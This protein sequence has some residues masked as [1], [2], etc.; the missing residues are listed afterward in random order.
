MAQEQQ[1]ASHNAEG[2]LGP[3]Q[4]GIGL[5]RVVALPAEHALLKR[6]SL[7]LNLAA[8]RCWERRD[9]STPHALREEESRTRPVTAVVSAMKGVTDRLLQVGA[10]LGQGK[11]LQA[12]KEAESIAELHRVTLADLCL[13]AVEHE[14]VEEEL[15]LLTDDLLHDVPVAR[16]AWKRTGLCLTGW[17]LSANDMPRGC[18]RRRSARRA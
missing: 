2:E 1:E 17:R 6:T 16:S 7:L 8:A 9:C 4:R 3:H 14:R 10:W 18:L 12:R 15:A 11:N 13:E 5:E